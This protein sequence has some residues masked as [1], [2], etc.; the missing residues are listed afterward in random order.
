MHLQIKMVLLGDTGFVG[1]KHLVKLISSSSMKQ[2][3][4]TCDYIHKIFGDQIMHTKTNQIEANFIEVFLINSCLGYNIM[5]PKHNN[6][7]MI[8]EII[9]QGKIDECINL[10]IRRI[11]EESYITEISDNIIT[12]S[13]NIIINNKHE[14]I[15]IYKMKENRQN[16]INLLKSAILDEGEIYLECYIFYETNLYQYNNLKSIELTSGYIKLKRLYKLTYCDNSNIDNKIIR[17]FAANPLQAPA[18]GI[19][20]SLKDA[21]LYL[22]MMAEHLKRMKS[23]TVPAGMLYVCI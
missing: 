19:F 11:L 9:I 5:K 13:L 4:I 3:R 15:N 1:T 14:N 23:R 16:I 18:L 6:I 20:P 12:S 8:I 2:L 17:C 21:D 22:K 7:D 10:F